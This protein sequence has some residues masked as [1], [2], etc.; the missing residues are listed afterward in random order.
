MDFA[1]ETVL[2]VEL[3]NMVG[4]RA[5]YDSGVQDATTGVWRSARYASLY[6]HSTGPGGFADNNVCG[7]K[8]PKKCLDGSGLTL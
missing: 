6:L 1:K 5:K 3:S 2:T 7:S 8:K 4:A